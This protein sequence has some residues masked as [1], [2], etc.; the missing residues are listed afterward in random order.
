M[1]DGLAKQVSVFDD[2]ENYLFSIAD[3]EFI[4]P[5]SVAVDLNNDRVYVLDTAGHKVF[6]FDLNG[7]FIRSFGQRGEG[8][9]EFNFPTDVDLEENLGRLEACWGHNRGLYGSPDPHHLLLHAG[10]ALWI[11]HAA[12]QRSAYPED[13]GLPYLAT[14]G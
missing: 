14:P 11:N 7:S 1:V 13:H 6:I 5:S 4:R 9:G 8:S 10:F 3:Q 12:L 2:E